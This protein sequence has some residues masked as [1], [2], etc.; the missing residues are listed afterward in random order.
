MRVEYDEFHKIYYK[1]ETA[2]GI[3]TVESGYALYKLIC[4]IPKTFQ[5]DIISLSHYGL[6]ET[7]KDAVLWLQNREDEIENKSILLI[8]K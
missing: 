1:K 4:K 6:V 7:L 5:P 8:K 2:R 3:K